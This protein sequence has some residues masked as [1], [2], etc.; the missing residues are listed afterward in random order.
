MDI[1]EA[2]RMYYNA[3]MRRDDS[4]GNVIALYVNR[5]FLEKHSSFVQAPN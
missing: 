4:L 1:T 3:L 2:T 5:E